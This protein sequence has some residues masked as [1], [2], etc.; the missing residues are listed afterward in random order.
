MGRHGSE[1]TLV[2]APLLAESQLSRRHWYASKEYFFGAVAQGAA[3]VQ[4]ASGMLGIG[5]QGEV[6]GL[7]IR[8]EIQAFA[9]VP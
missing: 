7:G 2:A 9:A 8:W 5:W 4:R 1:H 3:K 6:S